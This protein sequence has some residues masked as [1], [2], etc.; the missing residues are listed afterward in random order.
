MDKDLGTGLSNRYSIIT[1][2]CESIPTDNSG[3]LKL[4]HGSMR[5]ITSADEDER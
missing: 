4:A 5:T 2:I 1:L 3:Y